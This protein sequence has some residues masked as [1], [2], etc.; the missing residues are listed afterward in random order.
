MGVSASTLGT[1]QFTVA[2]EAL[3]KDF[4]SEA[5]WPLD[6]DKWLGLVALMH[7]LGD[8]DPK[9]LKAALSPVLDAVARNGAASRNVATL[10][11]FVAARLPRTWFFV[12]RGFW[13]GPSE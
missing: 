10:G 9:A 1:S 3:L 11:A 2:E 12:S 4:A 8:L 6:D 5:P 13:A 7:R